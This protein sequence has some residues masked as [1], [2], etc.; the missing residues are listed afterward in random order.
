[1]QRSDDETNFH[2]HKS[3]LSRYFSCC[4]NSS[5]RGNCITAWRK[6]TAETALTAALLHSYKA[7]LKGRNSSNRGSRRE[8]IDYNSGDDERIEGKSSCHYQDELVRDIIARFIE[9]VLVRVP[10]IRALPY[11]A[12]VL[13]C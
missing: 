6:E 2:F 1:V 7:E 10:D 12:L 3:K 9:L 11:I 8:S 13:P 5:R 4:I